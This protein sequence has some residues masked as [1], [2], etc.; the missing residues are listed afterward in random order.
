MFCFLPNP[1]K[2]LSI[3][4]FLMNL[5][6]KKQIILMNKVDFF[7]GCPSSVSNSTGLLSVYNGRCYH[8]VQTDLTWNQARS[9][10]QS[11]SGALASIPS[12]ET[13]TY[14]FNTAMA[15]SDEGIT[16]KNDY[17][18]GGQLASDG[19]SHTWGSGKNNRNPLRTD[20]SLKNYQFAC[21]RSEVFCGNSG[22]LHGYF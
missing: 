19:N 17:W 4:Q 11:R 10:C 18:L 16:S 8:F 2:P 3:A 13:Q 5:K 12:Q 7:L 22:F 15:L 20:F 21:R 14:L 1:T 6:S 9:D